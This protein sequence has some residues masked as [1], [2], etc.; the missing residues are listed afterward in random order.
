ML[1]GDILYDESV[2]EF[3][4]EMDF[5]Q[6]P[7]AEEAAKA[8]TVSPNPSIHSLGGELT[9]EQAQAAADAAAVVAAAAAVAAANQTAAVAAEKAAAAAEKVKAAAD[10]KESA[11]RKAVAAAKAAEAKARDT[12]QQYCSKAGFTLDL[13][14]TPSLDYCFDSGFV[15]LAIVVPG[16]NKSANKADNIRTKTDLIAKYLMKTLYPLLEHAAASQKTSSAVCTRQFSKHI[17]RV[18]AF[19]V[20]KSRSYLGHFQSTKKAVD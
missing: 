17:F 1:S 8:A 15:Q 11:V 3:A 14:T 20:S 2:F 13:G 5:D 4:S 9:D 10:A 7:P 12:L 19:C 18:S 16:T 6:I